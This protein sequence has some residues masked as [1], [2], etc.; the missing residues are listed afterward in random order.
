MNFAS[1]SSVLTRWAL[2]P[3]I[4]F[5]RFH[6]R[7]AAPASDLSFGMRRADGTQRITEARWAARPILWCNKL[8]NRRVAFWKCDK[9]VIGKLEFGWNWRIWL[10]IGTFRFQF[11]LRALA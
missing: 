7:T 1:S 3:D 2:P 8:A 11:A 9:Q 4:N 5:P 6:P 10:R